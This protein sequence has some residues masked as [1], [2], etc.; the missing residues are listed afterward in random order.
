MKLRKLFAMLLS[1]AMVTGLLAGCG[2]DTTTSEP[3]PV[4]PAPRL[5]PPLRNPVRP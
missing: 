3:P 4:S 2:G 1:L 5:R